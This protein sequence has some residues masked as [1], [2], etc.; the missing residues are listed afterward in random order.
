MHLFNFMKKLF[1]E[2]AANV[3]EINIKGK[4]SLAKLMYIMYLGDYI[5]FYHAMKRDVNPTPVCIIS[6]LKDELN[7]L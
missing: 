6:Q 2:T 7:K 1:L 5:S 3:I 4:S